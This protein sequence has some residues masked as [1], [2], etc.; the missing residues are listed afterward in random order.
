MEIEIGRVDEA[1]GG[2]G[3][4]V[5]SVGRGHVVRVRLGDVP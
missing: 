1:G 3:S 2:E 4:V 5:G